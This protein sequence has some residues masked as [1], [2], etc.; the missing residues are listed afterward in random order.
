[1]KKAA[2]LPIGTALSLLLA[3]CH[4]AP[5]TYR[6]VSESM[7]PTI[8]AND[9]IFVDGSDSSRNDLHDGDII[10]LRRELDAVVLKRILA[11]PGETIRGDDR[12]IFR[13][14]K[15]VPEP[16]LAPV[17][18]AEVPWM[19]SFPSRTIP[20]GEFFFLGDNRDHS[21][22]SRAE[23]YAPVKLSDVVGKYSFTYWHA[24]S[25]VQAEVTLHRVAI[26][27]RL[28]SGSAIVSAI[29]AQF[30]PAAEMNWSYL[31]GNPASA[32]G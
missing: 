30:V 27:E 17:S 28:S 12:K 8:L 9:R 22:D 32:H 6:N 16:Y 31:C 1:M 23:E 2:W 20:A 25:A 21:L 14:G 29:A 11:M 24:G 10:A 19:T 13:N 5:H 26:T 3:G 7:S 4:A 18:A 15:Q